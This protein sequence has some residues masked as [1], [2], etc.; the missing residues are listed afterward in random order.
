MSN[1]K[2]K[3]IWTEK[4]QKLPHSK[5]KAGD[6]ATLSGHPLT[7]KDKKVIDIWLKSGYISEVTL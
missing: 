2:K 7:Y 1:P 6:I 5:A 3:Y 4:A